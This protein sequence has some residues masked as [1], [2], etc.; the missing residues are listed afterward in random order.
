MFIKN[1]LLVI[2]PK[3][4]VRFLTLKP[5]TR[6]QSYLPEIYTLECGIHTPFEIGD[7]TLWN[8]FPILF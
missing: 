1:Q 5:S 4:K 7:P 8:Q 6:P 3:H 2:E